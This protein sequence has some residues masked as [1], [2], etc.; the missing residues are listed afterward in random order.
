MTIIG[1]Q[2]AA[3]SRFEKMFGFFE[4]NKAEIEF[5]DYWDNQSS[6]IEIFEVLKTS[7]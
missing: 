6:E 4:I 5:P 3:I 7:D 1:Y 2:Q